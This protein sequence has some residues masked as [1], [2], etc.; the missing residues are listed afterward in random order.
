MVYTNYESFYDGGVSSLQP[1]FGGYF[2]GYKMSASQLGFPGSA[3]TANQLNETVNAIKQGVK[4]FEVTLADV[5]DVSQIIPKQHF[6]EMRALMKLTGVKPSVH[7]PIIDAAGFGERG[8]GGEEAREDN[9][10]R[11]FDMIEKAHEIEP[12]GKIPI[13]FH[14]TQGIPGNEYVPGK[15]GEVEIN[16]IFAINLETKQLVPIEKEYKYRPELPETFK[17]NKGRGKLFDIDSQ[18]KSINETEWENKLTDLATFNKHADEVMGA[19]PAVLGEYKNAVIDAK[20]KIYEYDFEK[21]KIK[22]ELP[23]INADEG[24]LGYYKKMRDA[25]IFLENVQLNFTGAFHKA[26]KYGSKEQRER[27]EKLSEDYSK[28]IQ[29]LV[30]ESEDKVFIP[31]LSPLKKREILDESIFR[32]NEITSHNAPKV[33]EKIEDFAMG[34]AVDTFGNLAIKSYDKFKEKAPIIAIENMMQGMAFSRAEDLKKIIEDSREK[35]RDYLVE[36]KKMKEKD[37]EKLAEEKIGATWDVGHLNIMKKKGFTDEDII[38]ETKKIRPYVRHIHL[39]DNFG[40][41]DSHLPPGMG[42]VPIKAILEELE[43]SGRFKEMRKIVEA[44]NFVQHFKKSPHPWT[45]S[46]FGSPVYGMKS[47][48]QWNQIQDVVGGYFGG[49]GTINPQLHHS[50]YGAGFTTLP[51]ELGG[52]IPGAQGQSRFGGTPMA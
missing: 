36:E 43:K 30:V 41:S 21:D 28:K 2:V 8:W 23:P 27:L 4:A 1:D 52:T 29:N 39:T 48:P 47:G 25:D 50:I 11:M 40:F 44:P 17:D 20:G 14:T 37:A 34:K 45:L 9:E 32:L 3:M 42:N 35:F 15:E 13:V 22:K 10:R 24:K 38:K 51:A 7:G 26:Y 6:K 46:A 49:Y 31:V 16:K 5:Q 18:L 12:N 19:A 33:F